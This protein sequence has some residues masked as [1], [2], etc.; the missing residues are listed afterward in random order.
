L[1]EPDNNFTNLYV[2]NLDSSIDH[3]AL[4]AMFESIGPLESAKL[5]L[6]DDGTPTGI[7]FV[8]Y[9]KSEDAQKAIKEMDK[10]Q[11]P[12]GGIIFV[13]RFVSRQENLL[14]KDSQSL[15]PIAQNMKRTF[16]SNIFVNYL[17]LETTEEEVKEKF[18]V[19]GKILQL[20]LNKKPQKLF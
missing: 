5:K 19:T 1:S 10:S 9:R 12:S 16:D 2:T 15:T 8:N 17:P 11:T 6:N 20:R 13:T 4:I 14:Q 18:E 7:A 3:K